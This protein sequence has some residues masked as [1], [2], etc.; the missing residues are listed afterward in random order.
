[1]SI[2]SHKD[3]LAIVIVVD[4]AIHG[5]DRAVRALD[6]AARHHPGVRYFEP[7]LHVL[8]G[9]GILQGRRGKK[10]GYRLARE[11]G[12]IS[13]ADVIRAVRNAEQ[14]AVGRGTETEGTIEQMVSRTL[15]TA[16]GDFS[17]SNL[18]LTIEDLARSAEGLN[19]QD[20]TDQ[21]ADARR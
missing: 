20:G 18:N 15:E 12:L 13:V 4:V 19:A 5:R 14:E 10:G 8:A 21:G 2:V 16:L 17:E 9:C 3:L 1:M 6:I 11:A 7:M